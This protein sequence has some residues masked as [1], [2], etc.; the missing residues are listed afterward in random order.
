MGRL[1]LRCPVFMTFLPLPNSLKDYI[2]YKEYDLYGQENFTG[3][4]NLNCT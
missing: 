4:Y 3:T 1:R 2:L